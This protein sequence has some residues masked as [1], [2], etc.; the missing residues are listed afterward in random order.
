MKGKTFQ[1][2][3]AEAKVGRVVRAV[4]DLAGIPAD[5]PGQVIRAEH[6]LDGSCVVVRWCFPVLF[7]RRPPG[8]PEDWFPRHYYYRWLEE[9]VC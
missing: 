4:K 6:L 8:T 3:E 1:Y 2:A 5:T 9:V 7:G